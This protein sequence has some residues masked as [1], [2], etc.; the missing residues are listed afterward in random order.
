MTASGAVHDGSVRL[1]RRG[2]AADGGFLQLGR[3]L[4]GSVLLLGHEHDATGMI[5]VDADCTWGD[6]AFV[7]CKAKDLARGNLSSCRR[8]CFCGFWYGAESAIL[9]LWCVKICEV[10]RIP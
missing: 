5:G 7:L 1:A 9:Y 2:G 4:V 3:G 6:G 8:R 10:Q